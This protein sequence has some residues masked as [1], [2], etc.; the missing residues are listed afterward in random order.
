MRLTSIELGENSHE[1]SQYEKQQS[2]DSHKFFF[3]GLI[4]EDKEIIHMLQEFLGS[5]LGLYCSHHYSGSQ[6]SERSFFDISLPL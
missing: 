2:Y 3:P 1:E 4:N 5:F 6:Q